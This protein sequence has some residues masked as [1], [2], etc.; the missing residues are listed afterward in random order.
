MIFSILLV[1][2]SGVCAEDANTTNDIT[3][4]NEINQISI[5]DEKQNLFIND[6]QEANN[7][8]DHLNICAGENVASPNIEMANVDSQS[9]DNEGNNTKLDIHLPKIG[10][11]PQVGTPLPKLNKNTEMVVLDSNSQSFEDLQK[12]ISDATSGDTL[13]L[14]ENYKSQ[15]GLQVEINKDLTIDGHGHTLDFLGKEGYSLLHSSSGN[16]IL[17]N[18]NLINGNNALTN[19]GGAIHFTES[20]QLTLINCNF[21][22]NHASFGGAVHN[23][24]NKTLKII[25]CSFSGNT[26]DASGG[27][28]FSKGDVVLENSIF[29][30]NTAYKSGGAIWSSKDLYGKNCSF[31]SNKALENGRIGDNYGG[32]IFAWDIAKFDNC[33]FENNY[34]GH[35]GGAVYATSIYVNNNQDP[36]SSFNSFFMNNV[37]GRSGGALYAKDHSSVKNAVFNYNNATEDGGAIFSGHANVTHCFFESNRVQGI[38][39]YQCEGGAIHCLHDLTLDNSTFK[40]NFAY[41]YGGAILADSIKWMN[42]PSIFVGNRVDDNDGGAIYTNTIEGDVNKAVFINNR[43]KNGDGGAVYINKE[44]T[45]SF[46]HCTFKDNHAGDEGGAIYLDS[47]NSALSLRYNK[48]IDNTAGDKGEIVYNCGKYNAIENNWYGTDK[49]NLTN[50]FKECHFFG[51]EDHYDSHCLESDSLIQ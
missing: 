51:D 8:V 16:I 35:R 3:V 7:D 33:T 28:I 30:F 14:F 49:P 2:V 26:A 9:N 17:K 36:I 45:V 13:D 20:A 29:N 25:N 39:A 32:A 41:D 10:D 31:N 27:A 15:K 5:D 6:H 50:K 40:Y 46:S 37:A 18:L 21:T 22:N 1:D 48:L 42:S 23:S 44:N 24:V 11:A 38:R 19:Y 12:K 34:A 4:L 43:A 47:K